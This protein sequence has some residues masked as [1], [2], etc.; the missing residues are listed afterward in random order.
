MK[1]DNLFCNDQDQSLLLRVSFA[2]NGVNVVSGRADD[3]QSYIRYLPISLHV[4]AI[5][6]V[7]YELYGFRTL[8]VKGI[9]EELQRKPRETPETPTGLE[10]MTPTILV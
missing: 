1:T 9:F 10:R 6:R 3:D 7:A 2:S 4:H 5:R 8:Q